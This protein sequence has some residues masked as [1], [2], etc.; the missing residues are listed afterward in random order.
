MLQGF[1]GPADLIQKP[2]PLALHTL[3]LQAA[4]SSQPN[5][6][7]PRPLAGLP[8]P[9]HLCLL[10]PLVFFSSHRMPALFLCPRLAPNTLT[11]GTELSFE[12]PSLP[13]LTAHYCG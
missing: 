4:S 10:L 13:L 9:A 2:E 12:M 11:T 6:S 1:P 3:A 5:L 8:F 7:A